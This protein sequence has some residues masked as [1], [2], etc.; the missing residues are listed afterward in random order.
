MSSRNEV[1]GSCSIKERNQ[2]ITV[3]N[4]SFWNLEFIWSLDIGY[5]TLDLQNTLLQ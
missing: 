4:L 2:Q 3:W 5:W 1:T